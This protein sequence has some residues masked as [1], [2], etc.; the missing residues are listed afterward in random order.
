[1]LTL[2]EKQGLAVITSGVGHGDSHLAAFDCAELD[3]NINNVNAVK[4]SSFIPAKWE[5]SFDKN[6]LDKSM[7]GRCLPMAYEYKSSATKRST[8]SISIGI[9]M[10]KSKPSIVME[11]TSSNLTA[12]ELEKETEKSV[13][14]VFKF[15]KW[16]LKE[17]H[18]K[19]VEVLPK[20]NKIGCALVAVVYLP[21]QTTTKSN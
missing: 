3:A 9:P 18:S 1:M 12:R 19:S 21:K 11:H 16:E 6:Q 14:D 7:D 5:L 20:K 2:H 13:R 10:D 17:C 4:F 8:A 15:R